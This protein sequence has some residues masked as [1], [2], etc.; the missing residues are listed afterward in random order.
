MIAGKNGKRKLQRTKG[1]TLKLRF[2][3]ERLVNDKNEVVAE[4]LLA[5]ISLMKR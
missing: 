3:V 4:W 1:K 5:S 2:I